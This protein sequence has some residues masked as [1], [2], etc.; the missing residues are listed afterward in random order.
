MKKSLLS[1]AVLSSLAG[2]TA[3]APSV[4]FAQQAS[5]SGDAA[6]AR[7]E[8]LATQVEALK[9]EVAGLKTSTAQTS[10]ATASSK[11]NTVKIGTNAEVSIY[12]RALGT[13][14]YVSIKKSPIAGTNLSRNRVTTSN[15]NLGFRGELDVGNG[16]A[17][18]FQAEQ[19]VSLDGTGTNTFADRNSGL[20]F[21]G[22]WGRVFAGKWDTPYKSQ[23]TKVDPFYDATITSQQFV[24]GQT[25]QSAVGDFHRRET[26]AVQYWT[27]NFN[28]FSAKFHYS[29]NEAKTATTNPFSLSLGVDYDK[30][31]L[32]AFAGYES[33]Q[34]SGKLTAGATGEDT[35]HHLGGGYRF[36]GTTVGVVWESL[37]Y[38]SN[39]LGATA[40]SDLKRDALYLSAS[41]KFSNQ[42]VLRGSFGRADDQSGSNAAAG[43]NT[44]VRGYSLGLGYMLNGYKAA[45]KTEI[46][47][48]Y[49]NVANDSNATY[50]VGNNPTGG[51]DMVKTGGSRTAGANL[52]GFMIGAVTYF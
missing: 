15:S 41:H 14:E 52:S 45:D 13:G 32:F 23:S 43:A 46:F 50:G 6:A 47:A 49:V 2:G 1:I 39:A 28:G 12:G 31:P 17:L 21:K 27:P 29:A 34:D 40:A 48:Q 16:N 42:F 33:H 18:F 25:S 11:K 20:G 3:F 5:P 4:V 37:K 8:T 30:G 19:T 24:V 44:G 10:G 26:N 51:L 36:G 22:S 9:A 38:Q 7:L 35:G